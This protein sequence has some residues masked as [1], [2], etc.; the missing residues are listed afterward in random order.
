MRSAR[1]ILMLVG[2]IALGLGSLGG[3]QQR[4]GGSNDPDHPK[5]TGAHGLQPSV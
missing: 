2:A 3:T 1:F 4:S 5:D